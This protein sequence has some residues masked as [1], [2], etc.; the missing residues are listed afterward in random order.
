MVAVHHGDAPQSRRPA[1][2]PRAPDAPG[3]A[4]A[5]SRSTVRREH[6]RSPGF[7]GLVERGVGR[8]SAAA[9]RVST[10]VDGPQRA[11]AGD[12]EP[13][14]RASTSSRSRPTSVASSPSDG[15]QIGATRT[16][17]LFDGIR[18]EG[19][20]LT[21]EGRREPTLVGPRRSPHLLHAARGAL[22]LLSTLAIGATAPTAFEQ[23]GP[24]VHFEDVTRDGR[25]L[26]FKSLK[27]PL[28][29]SG[30]SVSAAPSD[31]RSC[32]VNSRRLGRASL[33]T[34]TGWR[35][36]SVCRQASRSSPNPSTGRATGF[37]CR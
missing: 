35:I 25:Y 15:P 3:H 14:G 24:F 12:G 27:Q 17:W 13:S 29:K 16:L 8:R 20:R 10:G 5:D 11:R 2:R 1:V 34:A 23:P 37:R 33:Q 32:K 22:S 26:V 7:C 31:G 6:R 30:S 36:R 9:D 28:T 18:P 19:T 21:Y 4:A